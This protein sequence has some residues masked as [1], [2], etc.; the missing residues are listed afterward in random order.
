MALEIVSDMLHVDVYQG[1]NG[2]TAA[3]ED[4]RLLLQDLRRKRYLHYYGWWKSYLG[5]LDQEPDAVSIFVARRDGKPVAILPLKHGTR[6]WYGLRVRQWDLPEHPHLPLNDILLGRGVTAA[7]VIAALTRTLREH[8]PRGWDVLSFTGVLEE[9]P[10]V[11]LVTGTRG[12]VATSLLK[13]CDYLV[14]RGTYEDITEKFSHNFRSNLN[15]ARNKLARVNGVEFRSVT[16]QPELSRAFSEFVDIEASGWKGEKGTGTA[17]KL[18]PELMRFYQSVIDEFSTSGAVTINSLKAG[19][20]LIASQFCVK[21]EDTLYVLKLAYDEDW[22]RVAPGNML[23]ERVI[24]EGIRSKGFQY[25]NLVGDPP[26][27]KDWRPES[28]NVYNIWLYNRT[29]MGL[30]LFG[31]M[32]AKQLLK[33]FYKKYLKR[34]R[35]GGKATRASDHQGYPARQ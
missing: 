13:T 30:V 34:G 35:A 24:Q 7:E 11:E 25:V 12:R 4:W 32:K 5:A 15:K 2:M 27:F 18:H 9:S 1:R 19:G 14:C 6:K 33:P 21:D 8:A 22:S 28:Q 3:S 29:P 31:A 16:D 23:F 20:K 26:W 17:I 10:L